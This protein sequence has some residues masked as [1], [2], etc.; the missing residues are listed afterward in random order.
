MKDPSFSQVLPRLGGCFGRFWPCLRQIR[1]TRLRF[2]RH[3]YL[4]GL[5]SIGQ[6]LRLG[7]VSF[8]CVRS[9]VLIVPRATDID[10][11][12]TLPILRLPLR[13]YLSLPCSYPPFP[14]AET[15]RSSRPSYSFHETGFS[16]GPYQ[17]AKT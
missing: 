5:P 3:P 4:P 13:L 2:T 16:G 12:P 7:P 15:K 17:P 6:Y 14:P 9:G 10:A 8:Q 1:S 11:I